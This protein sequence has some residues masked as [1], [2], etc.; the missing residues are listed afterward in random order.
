M[1]AREASQLLDIDIPAV[2][3]HCRNGSLKSTK[4]TDGSYDI[5]RDSLTAMMGRR[6]LDYRLGRK[7]RGRKPITEGAQ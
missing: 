7:R 3:Y 4:N 1:Q 5:D 6:A 2:L